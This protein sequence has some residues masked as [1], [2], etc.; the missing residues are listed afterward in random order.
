MTRVSTMVMVVGR[1]FLFQAQNILAEGDEY[2][3]GM[4]D[5]KPIPENVP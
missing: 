5:E 3:S 4:K 1:Q 2:L